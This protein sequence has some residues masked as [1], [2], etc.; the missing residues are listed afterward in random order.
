M[1]W[2]T[3]P[4]DAA[5]NSSTGLGRVQCYLLAT[6]TAEGTDHTHTTW[7]EPDDNQ[8]RITAAVS[9]VLAHDEVTGIATA[10]DVRLPGTQLDAERNRVAPAEAE[11]ELAIDDGRAPTR[12][13]HPASFRPRRKHRREAP[14]ML[15]P[16]AHP[17]QRWA[18][19]GAVGLLAARGQIG[20]FPAAFGD[21]LWS[22]CWEMDR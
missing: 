11:R 17:G 6:I 7:Y 2:R 9:W 13:R 10:G 21:T 12:H 5:S 16:Q 8:A 19:R 3:R 14:P 22:V 4:P 18:L 20:P 15:S 1:L